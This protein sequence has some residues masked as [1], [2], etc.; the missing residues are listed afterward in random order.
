M[1][2]PLE[3]I[4]QI[5]IHSNRCFLW[6]HYYDPEAPTREGI[7]IARPVE[8]NG[9]ETTY[10]ERDYPTMEGKLFLGGN[11]LQTAWLTQNEITRAFAY[12]GL[13][14]STIIGD[15]KNYHL[16]AHF[17]GAYSRLSL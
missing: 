4:K 17:N 8:K 5:C 2:D 3:L 14:Q 12:F 15:E 10:F 7:R 11:R 1:S 6:T 16:G 9:F 13:R